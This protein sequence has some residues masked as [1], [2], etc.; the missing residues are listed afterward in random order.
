MGLS[1]LNEMRQLF[2]IEKLGVQGI[3]PGSI[4]VQRLIRR[5]KIRSH[6]NRQ[7][8][9]SAK[10]E[11]SW[12]Y[13]YRQI[14]FKKIFPQIQPIFTVFVEPFWTDD[15]ENL[16]GLEDISL[17]GHSEVY[18]QLAVTNFCY[19]P[20]VYKIAQHSIRIN[21]RDILLIHQIA[22]SCSFFQDEASDLVPPKR[23]ISAFFVEPNIHPT[24]KGTIA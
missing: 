6:N 19:L 16:I 14:F 23:C 5:G 11:R 13:R 3:R 17:S 9:L 4:S 7:Y 1:H 2:L 15:I 10:F 20:W 21:M 18:I 22:P 24:M 12:V 8:T